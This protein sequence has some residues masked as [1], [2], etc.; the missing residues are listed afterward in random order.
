VSALDV[1]VGAQILN[2][3]R[4]LHDRLDLSLL[5]ISHNLD[6]VHYLCDTIAVMK[7]GRI[8][9][10]GDARSIY[11]DPQ[12]EYTKQLLSAIPKIDIP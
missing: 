11:S 3:L 5:F 4:E 2:L 7:D 10:S 9:E 8:V 12:H 1:S 6:I